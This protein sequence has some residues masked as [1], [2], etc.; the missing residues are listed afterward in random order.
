MSA[1]RLGPADASVT[2]SAYLRSDGCGGGGVVEVYLWQ[3]SKISVRAIEMN[4]V[5]VVDVWMYA[6]VVE[7]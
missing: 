1:V 6:P 5:V 2:A 4:P 3:H 7:K